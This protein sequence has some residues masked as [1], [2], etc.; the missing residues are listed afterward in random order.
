M[1]RRFPTIASIDVRL[2]VRSDLGGH[3]APTA[4]SPPPR[5]SGTGPVSGEP[6]KL[7]VGLELDIAVIDKKRAVFARR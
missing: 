6:P 2:F 7:V 1:S 4:D 3:A 5:H